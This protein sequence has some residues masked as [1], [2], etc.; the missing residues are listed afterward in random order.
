MFDIRELCI[1][2][3]K[4]F[5]LSLIFV[6]FLS[7]CGTAAQ[8]AP[9]LT[10]P[11]PSVT[12]R[13]SHTPSPQPSASPTFTQQPNLT[14]TPTSDAGLTGA[15]TA[16]PD[17]EVALSDLAASRHFLIGAAVAV[18]PLGNDASYRTLL[19]REFNLI[20][21]ENAMKWD[22]T[23][24]AR[25]QFN[26]APGDALVQFAQEHRMKVRGHCLVWHQALPGWVTD[27]H[28]S[29]EEW[30]QILKDHIT[31]EVTH[32][33]GKVFAWDVLN[34]GMA[35]N[36]LINRTDWYDN[37]GP[38]YIE[39]AFRAARAADPDALLFYNDY[40][41][42][43]MNAK[44][45]AIYAMVK[46]LKAEGVPIDGV[47]LQ[48]HTSAY[49]TPG[50]DEVRQN[51]LRLGALGLQV[52]ITEMDVRLAT[53]AS[54]TDLDKQA[55]IYHDVAAACLAEKACTALLF[56]GFTDRYSWIPYSYSHQGAGLPFDENYRRKPAYW[57]LVEALKGP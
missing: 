6:L 42:E 10:P 56:W 40:N 3:R 32:Y 48:M 43:G 9:T 44:S 57:S 53:P 46:E 45:D 31:A 21:P 39:I 38:D 52:H 7:A 55:R 13:P 22:T 54:R 34:E 29:R 4:S 26:F 36:G 37:I 8:P 1:M 51:I 18:D 50:A 28:F 11:I 25:G 14:L 15:L 41:A 47:G 30:I 49:F 12:A 23:E 2:N 20:V 33:K 17:S 35:D 27:G 16:T 5:P 24:P 19:A